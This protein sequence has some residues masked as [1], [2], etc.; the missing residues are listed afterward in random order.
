M[1]MNELVYFDEITHSLSQAVYRGNASLEVI[2]GL[3]RLVI[4]EGMWKRR[5]SAVTGDIVEFDTFEQYVTALPPEGLG[6][7]IAVL[8]CLCC[9]EV[10]WKEVLDG[11]IGNSQI[12]LPIQD[13]PQN[14]KA[15]VAE[16][17]KQPRIASMGKQNRRNKKNEQL[18]DLGSV[19]AT[20]KKLKRYLSQEQIDD[21]IARLQK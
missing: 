15:P 17:S 20:A 6:T 9:F 2:P 21:L 12:P 19:S 3:L 16:V 13:V 18:M 10:E 5:L 7:T 8:K 14:N 4:G 1:L 11:M